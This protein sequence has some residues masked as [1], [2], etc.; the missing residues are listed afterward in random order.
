MAACVQ[1]TVE[2]GLSKSGVFDMETHGWR[3]GPQN[4]IWRKGVDTTEQDEV[5]TGQKRC[6][7][8]V[9]GEIKTQVG[10]HE[11]EL[12]WGYHRVD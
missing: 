1:K 5:S 3:C 11:V 2:A 6:E 7:K 12:G 10:R 8:N 4:L 9:W